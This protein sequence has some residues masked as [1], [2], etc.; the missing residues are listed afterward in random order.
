MRTVPDLFLYTDEASRWF[1]RFGNSSVRFTQRGPKSIPRYDADKSSRLKNQ[2]A[3]SAFPPRP[4]NAESNCKFT[5]KLH[6]LSSC[7]GPFSDSEL[8]RGSLNRS[9]SRKSCS[10]LI[11][12]LSVKWMNDMSVPLSFDPGEGLCGSVLVCPA[13]SSPTRRNFFRYTLSDAI[14]RRRQ[15][16]FIKLADR[17]IHC[18]CRVYDC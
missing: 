16:A 5:K 2:G 14:A 1:Y 3:A 13:I 18:V 8:S 10:S 17:C 12:V 4:V 9:F 6:T 11:R 15:T 7:S